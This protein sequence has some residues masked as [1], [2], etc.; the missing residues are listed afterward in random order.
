MSSGSPG[1]TP[2]Q[3]GLQEISQLL[4]EYQQP[5]ANQLA[6][7]ARLQYF[8][9]LPDFNNYLSYIFASGQ[10]VDSAVRQSAGLLLKNSLKQRYKELQ[11]AFQIFIKDAVL[12]MV[13]SDIPELRRTAGTIAATIVSLEGFQVWENLLKFLVDGLGTSSPFAVQDGSVDTIVKIAEDCPKR[14]SNTLPGLNQSAGDGLFPLING[15]LNGTSSKQIAISAMNAM[16]TMFTQ[17]A[18][19][20]N[21]IDGYVQSVF[22]LASKGMELDKALRKLVCVAIVNLVYLRFDKLATHMPQ[23]VEYIIKNMQD[24]DNDVGMEA[25]EF[26]SAFAEQYDVEA[27][28]LRP[29][30][31][32]II[33]III[34]NMAFDDFDETVMEAE[35]AEEA[36]KQNVQTPDQASSIKPY[37]SQKHSKHGYPEHQNGSSPFDHDNGQQQSLLLQ[38]DEQEEDVDGQDDIGFGEYNLRKSSAKGLDYLSNMFES[39]EFLQITLPIVQQKLES[40]DWKARES[41]ILTL[42]AISFGCRDRLW[43][44]LGEIVQLLI[45]SA[46]DERPMIR[47]NACWALS[48][49]TDRVLETVLNGNPFNQEDQQIIGQQQQQYSQEGQQM[50]S[51]MLTAMLGC[52]RDRNKVVQCRVCNQVAAMLDEA[53][54]YDKAPLKPYVKGMLQMFADVMDMYDRKALRE[55]YDLI[56]Q[57]CLTFQSSLQTQEYYDIL[58]P[59]LSR[60]WMS[61]IRLEQ[62]VVEM[63]LEA[64]ALIEC[65][66]FAV[67]AFGKML[68]HQ[69]KDL[70]ITAFNILGVQLQSRHAQLCGQPHSIKFDDNLTAAATEFLSSLVEEFESSFLEITEG[71]AAD[72]MT[73]IFEFCKDS[74]AQIRQLSYGFLGDLAQHCVQLLNPRM[75][76]ALLLVI[77]GVDLAHKQVV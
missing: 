22:G 19:P 1:W 18:L 73:C 77:R 23:V 50:L 7:Y 41:A 66:R 61:V 13:K 67:Y 47:I 3:Q 53:Q 29:Y 36:A 46:N 32:T 24:D 60:K 34:K 21:S 39:E 52:L 49:Y 14:L 30:L 55:L 70:Y 10:A 64:G 15:L 59:V 72:L 48:R 20:E 63:D 40:S 42:G 17:I 65:M 54:Y 69:V 27:D 38:P 8:K 28:V 26:W 62:N 68:Q 44:H 31:P 25:S 71:T 58:M 16:N 43:V 76:E 56:G 5:G 75:M 37:S 35:E 2:Q 6:L 45:R 9:Q 51:Q 4:L 12:S 11:Q 57:C 74:E 33:P